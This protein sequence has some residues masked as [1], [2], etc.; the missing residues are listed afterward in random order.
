MSELVKYHN[1]MNSVSFSGFKEKELDLFFSLCYK[2]KNQ[3][4]DKI[5]IS[6]ED[7]KNLSS[8]QSRSI[9]RFISDLDSTYNKI[10]GLNMKKYIDE[11]TYIRFNLFTDYKVNAKEQNIT[12]RVHEEFVHI[13]N[14][15]LMNY[16]KFDLIDFVNLKSIYSKTMFRILKQ[17]NGI[18]AYNGIKTKFFKV[19]ELRELLG[20]PASYNN[21]KFNEKVLNPINSELKNI[22]P[23]FN[24]KKI[25]EGVK[26][27]EYKFTWQ[28]KED[29]VEIEYL[30][31]VEDSIEI[32]Q[33][34][35]ETIKFV[36]DHNRFIKPLLDDEENLLEL[37]NKFKAEETFEA[38]IKGLKHSL[39]AIQKEV[40]FN[41]LVENIKIGA[42]AKKVEQKIKIIEVEDKKNEVKESLN[43]NDYRQS[44]L[45]EDPKAEKE[46]LVGKQE[47]T[48]D[49]F[50]KIYQKYLKDNNA[51]D[52]PFTRQC[53]AVPYNIIKKED[54]EM[55]DEKNIVEDLFNTATLVTEKEQKKIY[56]AADIP[57]EMLLSK[58]GKK[59]TGGALA[60]RIKKILNEMNKE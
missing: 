16:T 41:Y 35:M 46:I 31:E 29:E 50:E 44:K 20:V 9:K 36:C 12:I 11:W 40:T 2:A 23:K 37:I 47:I 38:L 45:D 59:L 7:L 22:I 10:L 27:V 52:R 43:Q 39:K 54:K 4:T 5:T 53:F 3:G 55:A 57:E 14:N 21:S 58:T 42:R 32:P 13:L 8:Y 60:G 1:D 18:K 19:Q 28:V 33:K 26:V 49:E 51:E 25:K 6:F 15:L 48:E 30:P 34:V 56:T 17:W 24:I